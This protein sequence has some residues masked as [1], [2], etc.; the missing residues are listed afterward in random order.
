MRILPWTFNWEYFPVTFN[1]RIYVYKISPEN[2][3]E[4][5]HTFLDEKGA[6]DY[7]KKYIEVFGD[8]L[9]GFMIGNYATNTWRQ[10][11]PEVG[12]E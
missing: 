11:G 2:G 5:M 8:H 4:F 10:F 1:A 6:E 12:N 7:C 9:G 3:K